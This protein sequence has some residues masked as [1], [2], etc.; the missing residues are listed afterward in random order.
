M[1]TVRQFLETLFPDLRGGLIEI[2]AIHPE[3]HTPQSRFYPSI[4]ALLAEQAGMDALA[5]HFNVYLGVCPRSREAGTKDAV[6]LAWCLW[7]DL[8]AKSFP[9]GKEE[10]LKRLR[11]FPLPPTVIVDS[12]HGF[13]AYWRLK[14]PEKIAGAED[15]V[16]VEAHL[17]ALAAA[18]GGDSQAAEL[19]RIL[20]L[21]G[22]CNLKAPSTPLP[23]ALIECD[24]GRQYNLSDFQS[25]LDIPASAPSPSR[26][27]TGWI[28]EALSTLTEG[29]RNATFARIA[30][31]LRRDGWEADDI[32]VFLT[33]HAEKSGFPLAELR[34]EVEGLCRRYPVGK[35]SPSSPNN[36]GATETE[37]KP[38]QAL[39]LAAF[40]ESGGQTIE[41]SVERILPK[42][43]AGILA[44]PAGYGKSWM[45]L[46]LAIEC[47]R[48]G[49][50]L[51]QL[52]TTA[53]R[54]LY[55]DEESSP[56][57]LRKRLRKLLGGKKLPQDGLDVHFCV[58]QGFSLS[59]PDAVEQLRILLGSLRP[60]LVIIDSLIRVHRAEENSASEMAQVFEVVKN[61][62]R[63][64]RC[65]FLFADH[66]RK[67][68]HFGT[69]LD[70]LLRGSSE[71]A[72]FV[73]TLLS[74]QKKEESLIVEHSKS[75]CD[76]A[77]PAF[78]VEIKDREPDTTT[79]A[80]TGEA[81]ALKQEARLE[82]ARE[83][84]ATALRG[85]DWIARKEL[86][87]QAK[88]AEVSEKAVDEALKTLEAEG[89]L[90][91]ENRKPEGGRGGKAA[92]YRCKPISSPSQE[93]ETETETEMEGTEDDQRE[94]D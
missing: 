60:G 5:K 11:E 66:Q 51:G 1:A 71:K 18:L 37:S 65:A 89:R 85:G 57:L 93:R 9:G 73:D 87:E 32:L 90:E 19:A 35:P 7:I 53:T 83:F 24:P 23:V 41:W 55:L 13:H 20:R 48:G 26:N 2:R 74:L 6:K 31:R 63:E 64:Y 22:T 56:S 86:I 10:A 68:G 16:R 67:P 28:A 40:L 33:P 34:R 94:A 79:V 15:V 77:V 88:E 29:N 62:I 14:E 27:P 78:V 75:R 82:A 52:P 47:A 61:L 42:E 91:R 54:V 17:K 25:F 92:F 30:G 70:L 43:G 81:E 4:E 21:P 12:G 39:P 58:G 59:R 84:L 69:S 36:K 45:L 8:D 46:D 3:D 80:Y 76:E 49:K 50:W 72:A 38:L 44:G